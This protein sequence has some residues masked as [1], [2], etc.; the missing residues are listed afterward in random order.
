MHMT[1]PMR[2]LVA[3]VAAGALTLVPLSAASA[4]LV[5]PDEPAVAPVG[6]PASELTDLGQLVDQVVS[7]Q[8]ARDRIPGAAVV[9]VAGGKQVF[10]KGYGVSN[11][12]ARTPV[13]AASTVFFTGSVAKIFTATAA[14]Q[15]I[16]Q[17]KLDPS[18][19]VN[20]YLKAFKIRDT[21]PGRPVRVADLLTH[22]AGFDDDP[23]GVAVADPAA[24]PALGSTSPRTSPAGSARRARWRDTTITASRWPDIWCRSSPA[25]RSHSTSRTTSSGRWE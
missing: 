5:T 25:N 4:A 13:D 12:P 15:L 20:T 14:A 24:V 11:V 9:V 6:A 16:R 21:Y 3:G 2:I 17:G 1:R 7:T 19:D 22:T 18:A 23:R 10:A 8:L